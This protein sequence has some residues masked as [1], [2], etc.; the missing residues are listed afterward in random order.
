MAIALFIA[1]AGILV[2]GLGLAYRTVKGVL[3]QRLGGLEDKLESRLGGIEV[4]VD[5]RLEGLD[6]RLL[7]NQQTQGQAA[8]Q[9]V[10]QLTKLDGTAAQMLQQAGNLSKLEQALRPPKARGG[11]GEILLGKLLADS[12]PADAYQLQ[13]TF[14]SGDRVDAVIKASEKLLPVD[15]KF[16][17]DNFERLVNTEDDAERLLHERAFARDVKGHVDAI[18]SKYV[19]PAENTFD[20]AFM[21][22]PSE[23][24]YY[25]LVN[26]RTGGLYGYALGKRVFPVS[27]S[28]FHAF[29]LVIVMGLR[30]MQIERHAQEVMS[31][32]AQLAKDFERF[33]DDFETVG[34]H[35]GHAQKK[36]G[37]ADRR[38]GKL[39]TQLDRASEWEALP[40]PAAEPEPVRAL[41]AA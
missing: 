18:A 41:D 1:L 27:P 33:R 30:G 12:L 32:C 8:T 20:F 14:R 7:T 16:P 39:E 3:E 22:L 10:E 38:L 19:R 40:E 37:E 29:M 17:L 26:G 15:S 24:V 31:Y 23:S 2:V 21:Y 35:I 25:E 6:G 5:R 4:K 13:F 28:T 36:Y 11:F 9:I 34:T